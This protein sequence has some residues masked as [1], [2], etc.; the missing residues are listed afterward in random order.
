MRTTCSW[1]PREER[2]AAPGAERVS[3]GRAC[4]PEIDYRHFGSWEP[5]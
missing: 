1:S 3:V 2:F 4:F 5:A